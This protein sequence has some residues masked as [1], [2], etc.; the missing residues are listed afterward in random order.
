MVQQL[1]VVS[2]PDDTDDC[3]NMVSSDG[4]LNGTTGG[5]SLNN[6]S[7]GLHK[8]SF[9]SFLQIIWSMR[10]SPTLWVLL[11]R[12]LWMISFSLVSK[13][14]RLVSGRKNCVSASMST[15]TPILPY[16][17]TPITYS[18]CDSFFSSRTASS[19]GTLDGS[20]FNNVSLCWSGFVTETFWGSGNRSRI[21]ARVYCVLSS[22]T[23]KFPSKSGWRTNSRC[24]FRNLK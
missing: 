20:F 24:F 5:E 12:I 11:V 18:F 15:T 4:L 8:I 9:S 16:M 3:G 1:P 6:C 14:L 7:H 2:D 23:W 17:S 22:R 19:V 21:S 13:R 10:S